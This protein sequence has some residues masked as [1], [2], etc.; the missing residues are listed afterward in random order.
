MNIFSAFCVHREWED[1]RTFF[2]TVRRCRLIWLSFFTFDTIRQ[3][4]QHTDSCHNTRVKKDPKPETLKSGRR[5]GSSHSANPTA[6]L[7]IPPTSLC[8]PHVGDES[9]TPFLTIRH[10]PEKNSAKK[11]ISILEPTS[12]NLVRTDSADLLLSFE[13]I[14]VSSSR[15]FGV[16]CMCSGSDD[17]SPSFFLNLPAATVSKLPLHKVCCH[18]TIRQEARHQN[19]SHV[20]TLPGPGTGF[21][22]LNPSWTRK[23]K[24]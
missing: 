20:H 11:R 21:Q 17:E 23:R 24:Y 16:A 14:S 18:Q 8:Q 15:S 10:L 3:H 13:H 6:T 5:G 2:P 9:Q 19:A 12:W 1:A 4:T 22:G 7:H